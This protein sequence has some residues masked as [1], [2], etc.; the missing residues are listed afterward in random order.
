MEYLHPNITNEEFIDKLKKS[1]EF[2]TPLSFSRFGDGEICFINNNVPDSIIQNYLRST[3]K[4]MDI[5]T[6]KKDV[7]NIINNAIS[8]TDII[9]IMDKNNEIS[10]RISYDENT[11]SIKSE[12]V[13]R[14]RKEKELIVADHMVT[15]GEILGNIN[16]F[17]NIIQGNGV[18][19]ISPFVKLLKENNIQNLL[20]V[21]VNFVETSMGMNLNDR[22][23]MFL[24]FDKIKEPIVIYGCSLMGKD[25]A[26]HLKNRD[27]IALDFG[28][29]LDA[30]SGLFTRPWFQR[31]GLQS[32]CLI[33]KK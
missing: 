18:A 1:I 15:R 31:N 29:T 30:W 26:V 16:S 19:I 12:Y 4:Y 22:P 5:E 27:K 24:K 3:Y 20:G 21:D 25:F 14:L 8:E 9:G 6:A 7:L 32:H 17:K 33:Q 11:W 10:K 13:K 2:N 23:N 28:S